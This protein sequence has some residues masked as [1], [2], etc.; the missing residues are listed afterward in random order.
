MLVMPM[1]PW[2]LVF[3]SGNLSYPGLDN[4]HFVFLLYFSYLHSYLQPLGVELWEDKKYVLLS[5]RQYSVNCSEHTKDTL[6]DFSTLYNW[7]P[8]QYEIRAGGGGYILADKMMITLEIQT[9]TGP[10]SLCV[11]YHEPLKHQRS[12]PGPGLSKQIGSIAFL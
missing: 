3:F 1:L 11:F 10:E 2:D 6:T 7:Q 5:L 8:V 4:R 12:Q 9:V